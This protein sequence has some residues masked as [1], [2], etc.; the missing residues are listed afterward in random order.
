M[1]SIFPNKT[2]QFIARQWVEFKKKKKKSELEEN[3]KSK[4]RPSVSVL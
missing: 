3:N 2:M 1:K 4:V